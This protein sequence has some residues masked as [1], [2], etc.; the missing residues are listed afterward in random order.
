MRNT[1]G[2]IVL[3]VLVLLIPIRVFGYAD[4]PEEARTQP[5]GTIQQ[6]T[7]FINTFQCSDDQ[8]VQ[9]YVH[10][11]KGESFSD[12]TVVSD[13]QAAIIMICKQAIEATDQMQ[14]QQERQYATELEAQEQAQVDQAK[15]AAEQQ[16]LA[17]EA[18]DKAADELLL[19]QERQ[20]IEAFFV[21][22][23]HGIKSVGMGICTIIGYLLTIRIPWFIIKFLAIVTMITVFVIW[24]MYWVGGGK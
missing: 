8:K 22:I 16:R 20:Q 24:F 5:C 4:N 18:S 3:A 10:V 21:S 6:I 7:D 1:F 13:N 23:G 12:A 9:K 17:K 11:C 15:A 14:Q 19:K 2:G